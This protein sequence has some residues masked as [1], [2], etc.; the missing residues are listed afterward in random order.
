MGWAV[1][2]AASLTPPGRVTDP[3]LQGAKALRFGDPSG[4]LQSGAK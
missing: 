4:Q 2:T 3:A 1:S